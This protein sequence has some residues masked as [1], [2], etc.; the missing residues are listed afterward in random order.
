[1]KRTINIKSIVNNITSRKALG[2]KDIKVGKDIHG[3]SFND[4][5]RSWSSK[6][7]SNMC[8]QACKDWNANPDNKIKCSGFD[9]HKDR[10]KCF[11][12][13]TNENEKTGVDQIA[14]LFS[15]LINGIA[16]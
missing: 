5:E 2:N 9:W 12:N 16:K 11:L 8:L 14:Q 6:Q 10:R 15:F 4:D 7:D 13:A 1:M 3:K